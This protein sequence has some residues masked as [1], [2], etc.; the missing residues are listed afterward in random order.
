MY[1]IVLADAAFRTLIRAI[2]LAILALCSASPATAQSVEPA[3][4]EACFYSDQTGSFE[5][6]KDC[7]TTD[8]EHPQIAPHI[9]ESL[10]YD[11]GLAQVSIS[12]SGIYYRHRDGRMAQMFVF[13]NGP[14]PFSQGRARARIDGRLAY[15]DRRLRVR[16]RTG[17]DW[18]EPFENG[19]AAVCIG[20]AITP[21]D[22]GEHHVVTGGRWGVIDCHGREL[23]PLRYTTAELAARRPAKSARGCPR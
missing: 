1:I 9:V 18:G 23:V 19:R 20:C 10:H 4:T 17:Y 3:Y 13:D 6:A 11:Q 16:I 14:D 8:I 7:A 5:M 21:V 2:P 12:R 22:A 15:V